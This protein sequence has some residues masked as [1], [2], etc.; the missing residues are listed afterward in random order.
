MADLPRE[1]ELA[2]KDI[3]TATTALKKA[4]RQRRALGKNSSFADRLNASIVAAENAVRDAEVRL[5][6]LYECKGD[7]VPFSQPVGAR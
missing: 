6:T 2:E 7:Y 4:F 5:R 1:I 3:E